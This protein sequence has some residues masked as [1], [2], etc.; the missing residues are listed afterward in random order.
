MNNFINIFDLE[1]IKI[2]YFPKFMDFL[3]K[4]INKNTINL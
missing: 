4:K 3:S 2:Y 1:L